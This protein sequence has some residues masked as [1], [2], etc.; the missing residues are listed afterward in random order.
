MK[1]TKFF[2]KI[3]V[4]LCAMMIV[5]ALASCGEEKSSSVDDDDESTDKTSSVASVDGSNDDESAEDDATSEDA[6]SE[7]TSSEDDDRPASIVALEKYYQG[8]DNTWVMRLSAD[9]ELAHEDIVAMA[10]E[11]P[12]VEMSGSIKVSF[13]DYMDNTD[14]TAKENTISQ[15]NVQ[16][17]AAGVLFFENSV[18]EETISIGDVEYVL[19][20]ENKT[21]TVASVD[22]EE[23]DI[24]T[25]IQD[26]LSRYVE[27][28]EVE[29]DGVKYTVD[30]FEED[31]M[32]MGIFTKD[33]KMK[34]ISIPGLL[35][36]DIIMECELSYDVSDANFEIPEGYVEETAK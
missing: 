33:G 36:I 1:S 29:I 17:Y 12:G 26:M 11:D 14:L 15:T 25:E 6:T 3:S 9:L 8:D 7:N 4:F 35:P 23:F 31:E 13:V 24:S 22:D 32:R 28:D 18:V 10:G 27:T 21:Y 2:K 20:H 34:Y 16:F 30:Y 5:S 19:D